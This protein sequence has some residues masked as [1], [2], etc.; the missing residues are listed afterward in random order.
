MLTYIKHSKIP[1]RVSV[2]GSVKEEYDWFAS[3]LPFAG[4]NDATVREAQAIMRGMNKG[5]TRITSGCV[6]LRTV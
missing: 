3:F 2:L 6:V 1:P 4:R 5:V